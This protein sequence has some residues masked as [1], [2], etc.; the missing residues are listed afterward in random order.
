M[1]NTNLPVTHKIVKNM[2]SKTILTSPSNFLVLGSGLSMK[3]VSV[4]PAD[5]GWILDN[6]W[7]YFVKT[8]IQVV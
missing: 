8:S 1:L 3:K 4:R 6:K 5:F 2:T 7:F